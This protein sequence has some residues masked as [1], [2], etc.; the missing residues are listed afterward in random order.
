MY[1]VV[2]ANLEVNIEGKHHNEGEEE[3]IL[4]L[5]RAETA[6]DEIKISSD[7]ITFEG[8]HLHNAVA[9]KKSAEA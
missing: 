3:T 9:S 2:N 4:C 8:D 5:S 6:A 1:F 7:W